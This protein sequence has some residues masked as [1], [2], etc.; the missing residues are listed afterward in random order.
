MRELKI[1]AAVL[2]VAGLLI[3]TTPDEHVVQETASELSSGAGEDVANEPGAV[4]SGPAARQPDGSVATK[5][6]PGTA[7]ESPRTA[8]GRVG[9][10]SGAKAAPIATGRVGPGITKDTI[11]VGI[12]W[13]DV[14]GAVAAFGSPGQAAGGD[15]PTTKEGAERVVAWVNA[16]GGIAGRKVVPAYHEF[17]ISDIATNDSRDR[18]EQAMCSDWTEDR[19]AF[20]AIPFQDGQGVFYKCAAQHGLVG[21]ST[22]TT[23]G[24]ASDKKWF[25]EIGHTFWAPNWI[26]GERRE[27]VIVGQLDRVGFFAPGARV[28]LFLGD[29]P[30]ARS[31]AESTLKPMLKKLG[32]NVVAEVYAKDL[33]D[34]WSSHVFQFQSQGVT[35]IVGGQS[36]CGAGI[37]LALF[38]RAAEN[39]GYRPKYGVGSDWG[40][41]QADLY[42]PPPEQMANTVSI[43]WSPRTDMNNDEYTVA[44]PINAY[45]ARCRKIIK[46]SGLDIPMHLVTPYCDG[47]FFLKDGLARAPELTWQGF[48]GA[49]ESAGSRIMVGT[50]HRTAFGPGRHDGASY[51]RDMKYNAETNTWRYTGPWIPVG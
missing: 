37:C 33:S 2:M 24:G 30:P 7:G 1:T 9:G 47:L 40:A 39:Q 48:R 18:R 31:T 19:I 3:A 41:G 21:L 46:D 32:V 28:G 27:R 43:G 8:G 15:F 36:T 22:F 35:H 12:G 49:I 14:N 10:R 50:A 38:Q 5:A 26:K 25:A 20:A 16:N 29:V 4:T 34:P 6:V 11:T 42:A 13:F 51:V 23:G 44:P 45:D 17:P